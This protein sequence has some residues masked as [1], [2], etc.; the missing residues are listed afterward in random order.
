[1]PLGIAT[2][3]CNVAGGATQAVLSRR[4]A[5]DITLLGTVSEY[6]VAFMPS[7]PQLKNVVEPPTAVMVRYKR[8]NPKT[9]SADWLPSGGVTVTFHDPSARP[10]TIA[11]GL[12]GPSSPYIVCH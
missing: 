12:G 11:A 5:P 7:E 4:A 2:I 1:M 10:V 9:R 3:P 8:Q 6:A